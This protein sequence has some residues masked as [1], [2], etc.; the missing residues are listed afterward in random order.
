MVVKHYSNSHGTIGIWGEI[1]NYAYH[2]RD[3]KVYIFDTD[4][5]LI[6]DAEVIENRAVCG[7]K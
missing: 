5:Q 4:G 2:H 7:M 1:K 3:G 6:K